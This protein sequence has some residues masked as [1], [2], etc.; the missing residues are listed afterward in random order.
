VRTEA[1]AAYRAMVRRVEGHL[2]MEA[3][4]DVKEPTA[5]RGDGNVRYE[6]AGAIWFVDGINH[7]FHL[8]E[9]GPRRLVMETWGKSYSSKQ[10]IHGEPSQDEITKI[11]EMIL[12]P[13][14]R[15]LNPRDILD[16]Q[17]WE[18]IQAAVE[19]AAR[20]ALNDHERDRLRGLAARLLRPSV[21]QLC[22]QCDGSPRDRWLA[23]GLCPM[24]HLSNSLAE[25]LP[26]DFD[27]DESQESIL[28]RAV[29]VMA[30]TWENAKRLREQCER[31]ESNPSKTT[32]YLWT[33]EIR[34]LMGWGETDDNGFFTRYF[35]TPE[36]E[37]SE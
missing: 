14:I 12:H 15:P 19:G 7:G 24:C 4:L 18:A 11:L 37:K 28:E 34:N 32:W 36:K 20:L 8:D 10:E 26:D 27:G 33:M 22:V 3:R 30:N 31:A 1:F 21:T 17:D 6:R 29:H 2:D 23:N 25:R 9:Y 16:F 13:T 35:F 5:L